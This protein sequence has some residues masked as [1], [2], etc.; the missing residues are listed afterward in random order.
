VRRFYDHDIPEGWIK[1]NPFA[2]KKYY[3][4]KITLEIKRLKKSE[5]TSDWGLCDKYGKTI[6]IK[7]YNI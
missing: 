7:K 6:N 1:G 2:G 4:N 5:L 3:K